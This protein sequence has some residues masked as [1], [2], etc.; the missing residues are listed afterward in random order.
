MFGHK[1]ISAHHNCGRFFSGSRTESCQSVP[2]P[3][4]LLAYSYWPAADEFW[5]D[6]SDQPMGRE[7]MKVLQVYC[8]K[9]YEY[10]QGRNNIEGSLGWKYAVTAVKV[11]HYLWGWGLTSGVNIWSYVGL[12]ATSF[13][14]GSMRSSAASDSYKE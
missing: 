9:I 1:K 4:T 6:L 14:E 12:N 2:A 3:H 7:N 5:M 10:G 8:R 11:V 13:A